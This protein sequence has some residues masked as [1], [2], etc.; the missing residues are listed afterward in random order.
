M[1]LL[2]LYL[3]IFSI[4]EKK[5]GSVSAPSKGRTFTKAEFHW[6]LSII[7]THNKYQLVRAAFAIVAVNS[8]TSVH[9]V[10]KLKIKGMK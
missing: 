8:F 4:M 6:F 10:R 1:T 9:K 3:I 7:N 2:T 5:Y